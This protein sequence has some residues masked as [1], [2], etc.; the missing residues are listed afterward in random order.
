MSSAAFL[1][2]FY[3]SLNARD[4]RTHGS[5]IL[6]RCGLQVSDAL[7]LHLPARRGGVT[8]HP[9]LI[10]PIPR[11]YQSPIS[12]PRSALPAREFCRLLLSPFG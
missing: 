3:G 8:S 5:N 11:N 10:T 7:F 2:L 1:R 6:A 4:S 12:P 9:S